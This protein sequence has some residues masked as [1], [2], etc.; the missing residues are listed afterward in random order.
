M[1][2]V[3]RWFLACTLALAVLQAA[4]RDQR[5]QHHRQERD[6]A[7]RTR[8]LP[9]FDSGD[10]LRPND[11]AYQRMAKLIAPGFILP[12]WSAADTAQADRATPA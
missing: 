7:R 6:P 11:A 1:N 9:A 2:L 4:A 12:G 10:H 5:R 3:R 8:L